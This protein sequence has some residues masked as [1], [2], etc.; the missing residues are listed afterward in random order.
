MVQ[1]YANKA[2]NALARIKKFD[3]LSYLSYSDRTYYQT[4]HAIHVDITPPFT[5]AYFVKPIYLKL[6]VIPFHSGFHIFTTAHG[7]WTEKFRA[8]YVTNV[9]RIIWFPLNNLRGEAFHKR[10]GLTQFAE[11]D[12]TLSLHSVY[13]RAF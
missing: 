11:W 10:N 6:K 13:V 8:Q 7:N 5:K 4:T 2:K 9:E 12:L 3:L 1:I